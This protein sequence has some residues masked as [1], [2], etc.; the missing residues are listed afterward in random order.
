MQIVIEDGTATQGAC[1]MF[2]C[3]K[4][5]IIFQALTVLAAAMLGELFIYIFLKQLNIL[6]YVSTYAQVLASSV[7]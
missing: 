7:N 4:Y 6:L 1:G 3:Q 2:E 5:W